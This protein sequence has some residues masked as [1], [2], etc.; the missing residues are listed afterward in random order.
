M[1]SILSR[2]Q[3]DW[4]GQRKDGN[5]VPVKLPVALVT[6][7][8]CRLLFPLPRFCATTFTSAAEFLFLL[9]F[10]RSTTP[11]AM[12][13]RCHSGFLVNPEREKRILHDTIRFCTTQSILLSAWFCIWMHHVYRTRHRGKARLL[14][15]M[16][17]IQ[18]PNWPLKYLFEDLDPNTVYP[19][20]NEL[21][22]QR[23][24]SLKGTKFD[25]FDAYH[26]GRQHSI[27]E[28]LQFII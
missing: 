23:S 6:P 18:T 15:I 14:S 28:L 1:C 19:A 7:N 9:E 2:S 3:S 24:I 12:S 16:K 20:R 21:C 5:C 4:S 10:S 25:N 26:F 27:T 11:W 17:S 22:A 8:T 13:H